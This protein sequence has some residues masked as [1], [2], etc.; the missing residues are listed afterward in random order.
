[1]LCDHGGRPALSAV[2]HISFVQPSKPCRR[3]PSMLPRR[4]N[5]AW[6]FRPHVVSFSV[7]L[8]ATAIA[9]GMPTI[10]YVDTVYGI[11]N[12]LLCE[13]WQVSR[14]SQPLLDFRHCGCGRQAL[15]LCWVQFLKTLA[16]MCRHGSRSSKL[17]TRLLQVMPGSQVCR[18]RRD[19]REQVCG[20][21]QVL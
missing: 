14:I 6:T 9:S 20:F 10:S 7:L 18:M 8:E 21:W 4:S 13:H 12:S 17:A 1:M 11:V 2:W 16:L 5:V 19:R 3:K 15:L